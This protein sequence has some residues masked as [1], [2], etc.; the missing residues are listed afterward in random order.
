MWVFQRYFTMSNI[1]TRFEL[2][3]TVFSAVHF[4]CLCMT[5]VAP[6][7]TDRSAPYFFRTHTCARSHKK[8]NG[9]R[10]PLRET[11]ERFAS[12]V[13]V[14]HGMRGAMICLLLALSVRDVATPDLS[15]QESSTCR[16]RN[17]NL[18]RLSLSLSLSPLSCFSFEYP[19]NVPAPFPQNTFRYP[20][21]SN[22]HGRNDRPT[23]LVFTRCLSHRVRSS[24]SCRNHVHIL[25]CRS[26]NKCKTAFGFFPSESYA[27][28]TAFFDCVGGSNAQRHTQR[29]QPTNTAKKS[30]SIICREVRDSKTIP[31]DYFATSCG[32][33]C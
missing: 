31:H 17:Q 22:V 13:R 26:S 30:I 29:V 3:A 11:R 16:D 6:E 1:L 27:T 21:P 20:H 9:Q 4:L 5:I 8:K 10:R 24:V 18:L 7:E 25:C 33:C 23:H 14:A 12:P 28:L 15:Q 19:S 32:V 2:N